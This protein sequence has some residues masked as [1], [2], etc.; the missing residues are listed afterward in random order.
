MMRTEMRFGRG[1]PESRVFARVVV[2]PAPGG[3]TRI[4]ARLGSVLA[5]VNSGANRNLLPMHFGGQAL[6]SSGAGAGC[7]RPATE[8]ARRRKLR[9]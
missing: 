9:R 5:G 2:L 7:A 4:T 3:P 6:E 1:I 8:L